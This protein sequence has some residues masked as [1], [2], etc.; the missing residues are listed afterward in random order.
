MVGDLK[1]VK[2]E[3]KNEDKPDTKNQSKSSSDKKAG[4]GVWGFFKGLAG[5]KAITEETLAPVLNTMREHLCSKNVAI[6]IC[7]KLCKSVET[8][9]IGR[10]LGTFTGVQT[11]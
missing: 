5:Q 7:E 3:E 4:G 10:V 11:A 1:P 9:L 8:K 2:Y 6:D